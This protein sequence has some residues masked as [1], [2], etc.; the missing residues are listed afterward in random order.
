MATLTEEWGIRV[1][2]SAHEEVFKL[3]HIST[4]I[5]ATAAS[6]LDHK[7]EIIPS[8][9]VIGLEYTSPVWYSSA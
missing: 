2:L 8:G 5:D 3:Y 7:I 9:H 4:W 6:F 1:P